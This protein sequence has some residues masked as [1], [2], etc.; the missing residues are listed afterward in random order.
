MKAFYADLRDFQK[1]YPMVYLEVWTPEDFAFAANDLEDVSE[2]A[3]WQ[4]PE[5]LVTAH[6]LER[7]FDANH[8]T[9]WD[10]VR[11]AASCAV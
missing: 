10:R 4:S 11:E 5:H 2:N 1:K 6:T 9:N 7:R 3:D 8:G